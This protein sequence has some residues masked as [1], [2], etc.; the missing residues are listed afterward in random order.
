M[1][2]IDKSKYTNRILHADIEARGYLD[3][4]KSDKDVWCLVS[5]DD[6]TDEVFIFH[7]YPEYDN[8]EVFD[9]GKTYTIPPRTGTLLDGVRF[10]YLA[11]K[12]GSK[13][14][15]HNCFTYD[16]P[17][18]EKI[19]PK[20]KIDDD[21][22][23]DTFIQSK[24]QWFD[25]PQRKGS[26]SPH[27]LL[28]YSLMEGN[29][30]PDIE[31]FSVMNAFMLH[32]CIIDTKTQKFAHNYLKKERDMLKD[33]LGIDMTEAYKM[34]VE[35]TKNC[36]EQEQVGVLADKDHM[37]KC[38]TEWDSKA[39]E[40]QDF[41]EPILPPTIKVS[42]GKISRV[43]MAALFGYDTSGMKDQI[44]MVKRDGEMVEVPVK[45]YYKPTMNFHTTK[46]VNQYSAF[47]ISH[48][49]SPKFVKKNDLIKWIKS[50]HPEGDNAKQKDLAAFVKEWEVTKDIEETKLL[51]KNTCDYFEVEPE[52]TDIIVG[53]HT[54][55]K[56][57][58]S[59]L[60]QHEVVKGYLIKKGLKEV[61]EWNF[62]KD[63]EG[64]FLKAEEDTVISY[65]PKASKEN[66]LHYKVKK[67]DLLVSSPK[68]SEKDYDQ[69]TDENAKRVGEYNT[70]VHRRRFIS[71]PTD[72]DK[73]L[74]AYIRED[75]RLPCGINNFSTSSGR[76]SHRVWVNAAGEGSM[77]GEEIRKILIAPEGR[78]LV[79][80]DMAS[81]QLAI[82][83]FYARN[84][85]YYEAV[86][87]G[88]EL[89]KDED[90]NEFYVGMS[91]HC[92]SA[93]NFGMVSTEEFER[94][95]K[96][97]DPE[98]IHSISLRRKKSKGASFGVCFGCSG[99]KLAGMLGIP[100]SEGN[101][102]KNMFLSRMG[103]QGI[104]DWGEKYKDSF[105]RGKGFYLPLPFGYWAWCDSTHK[106]CNFLAQGA[107]AA[108]QKVA[109]NYFNK[110]VVKRGLDAFKVL[111]YH[112][113]IVACC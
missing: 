11:G 111:D 53:A 65:P 32:R 109:V 97:Q 34:E 12:N 110:E 37:I 78:R 99:K 56:F 20:C 80:A 84:A 112:K 52:D 39:K 7:D 73:G 92:H 94:A 8:K 54:K 1:F 40:I 15:V 35:Y 77:Y 72:E 48:G 29:K 83:S 44:E 113:N 2:N 14:S 60:T 13:L 88:L 91:A 5:R 62:K 38:I 6:E 46:K 21:V 63:S 43:E 90:G 50:Q 10:W 49:F 19:W 9:Q 67:G 59:K 3:V 101:A 36:H 17:L 61:S 82:L 108:C 16:K 24:I 28:N 98:L 71:N 69:L 102:K 100:E 31:D 103:L 57:V 66:Q 105:K 96:T 81:A 42:G 95:V 41:I 58:A 76:G 79:G 55:I 89:D 27:G 30:K 75:G 104:I 18:V 25:R 4:V 93:R 86:A 45:P 26:K 22:W 68:V 107:E 70:T 51:N 23:I 87:S 74:M 85:E 33:R 47:N 64:G 106:I